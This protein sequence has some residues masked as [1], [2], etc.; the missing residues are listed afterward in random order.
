M[1]KHTKKHKTDRER[2]RKGIYVLPN[3]FTTLNLFFGFTAVIA[4]LQ[5][6]F[7]KGALMILGA[8]VFDALDGKIA[9]ATHTTSRFGVEY[10]SLSDL[11]SFGLAPGILMYLWMLQPL[12]KLGWIAALIFLACGALRLAR[13]N[14]HVETSDN[15]HFT[16]LPI[17]AAA[18]ILA[19]LVLFLARLHPG[20]QLQHWLVYLIPASMYILSFLMVSSVPYTSFK[21]VPAFL[22]KARNLNVL[23]IAVLLLV[24]V[25]Q[26]PA[27]AVFTIMLLYIISGPL[28]SLRRHVTGQHGYHAAEKKYAEEEE[29]DTPEMDEEHNPHHI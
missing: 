2:L 7:E 18:C 11:I 24:F 15:T 27:V 23:V 8:A 20:E 14:T 1:R 29:E 13:F 28:G 21:R 10:D 3:I 19:A 4:A 12:E 22:V 16:G 17:P 6:N 26:E 5:G 9:R 25:I